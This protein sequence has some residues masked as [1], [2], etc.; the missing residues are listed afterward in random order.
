MPLAVVGFIIS[1]ALPWLAPV[2]IAA[3]VAVTTHLWPGW[4]PA[5]VVISLGSSIGLLAVLAAAVNVFTVRLICVAVAGVVARST[6]GQP[7]GALFPAT[8]PF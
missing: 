5:H 2:A 6:A 7:A 1:R 8:Q 4:A 3:G